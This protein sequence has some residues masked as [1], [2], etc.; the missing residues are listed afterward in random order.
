[1]STQ[2]RK[3]DYFYT[4]IKDEP[5]EAYK[6][7]SI[8]EQSGINLLAI[9]A[10][11]TGPDKTQLTIFPEENNMLTSEA[12][13][14]GM[15]LEGPHHAFL[16]QGDDELGALATIHEKLYKSNVNIYA[17]MGITDGKGGYGYLLYIRPDQYDTAS[18]AL[19]I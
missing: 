14:I 8:L 6:V 15:K 1:M 10:V 16:I 17:S 13:K 3:V 5:G 19:N 2:I 9:T 11:P 4:S 12:K 7:L 18:K